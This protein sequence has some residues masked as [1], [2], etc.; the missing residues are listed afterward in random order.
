MNEATYPKQELRVVDVHPQTRSKL[1]DLERNYSMTTLTTKTTS[2]QA[3]MHPLRE[4]ARK[5]GRF[6]WHFFEMLI[7][8]GA[9]MGVF[10]LFIVLIR[11]YSNSA[12]IQ[13]GTAL[14]AIVMAMFMTA[15]MVAWM[16]VR[17]H[18]W[19]HSVEMAIAMLGP[20]AA[21]GLL[22]QF[23]ADTY[24]PW[25]AEASCPAM[26]IGMIAA[27]LYRRDHYTR[28][29]SHIVE[30]AKEESAPSCH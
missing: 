28:A 18:G 17:G 26:F 29:K 23:G 16:I 14:H 21:V 9:G 20:M 12:V 4:F 6:F 19:R 2:T 22:C 24:L 7:A 5:T 13:S 10:H 8:M 15:P 30:Y 3:S 1:N 11:P 27:M 25:L